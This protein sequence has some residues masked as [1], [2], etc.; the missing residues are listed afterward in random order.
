MALAAPRPLRGRTILVIDDGRPVDMF[1]EYLTVSGAKVIE[2]GSAQA[3]LAVIEDH[4]FDAA[5]VDLR[6]PYEDGWSFLRQLRASRHSLGTDS[7]P[8]DQWRASR[9]A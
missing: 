7:G 8:P 6:M 4:V 5:V 1:E 3:P 9:S 2:V